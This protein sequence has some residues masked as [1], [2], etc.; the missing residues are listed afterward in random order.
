[1]LLLGQQVLTEEFHHNHSSVYETI[2][3]NLFERPVESFAEKST[4]SVNWNGIRKGKRKDNVKSKGMGNGNVS[5][6]GMMTQGNVKAKKAMRQGKDMGNANGSRNGKGK[7]KGR[8][9][10]PTDKPTEPPTNKPTQSPTETPP[11]QAA[12]RPELQILPR[13]LDNGEVNIPY[14]FKFVA[15]NIPSEVKSLRFEWLPGLGASGSA[16]KEVISGEAATEIQLVYSA[17]GSYNLTAS[18]SSDTEVLA[19]AIA[20]ITIGEELP[21]VVAFGGISNAYSAYKG[22]VDLEWSP[23]IC[24]QNIDGGEFL[25]SAPPGSC[26]QM[27]Y[28]I[29]YASSPYEFDCSD[30]Q[31]IL[32]R[33]SNGQS[34]LHH[35]S[36]LDETSYSLMGLQ[37]D[38][39]IVLL[40]LAVAKHEKV[41]SLVCH[42]ATVRV[43]SQDPVLSPDITVIALSAEPNRVSNISISEP[44]N[45]LDI[46]F[47]AKLELREND[48][49]SGIDMNTGQPFLVQIVIIE[50]DTESLF[51]GLVRE[52][53][54]TEIFDNLTLSADIPSFVTGEVSPYDNYGSRRYLAKKN[55]NQK[56]DLSKGRIAK[57]KP[58]SCESGKSLEIYL[59][60]EFTPSAEFRMD[61][62]LC[63]LLEWCSGLKRL[64]TSLELTAAFDFSSVIKYQQTGE[65]KVEK[66]ST[67]IWSKTYT[68]ILWVGKIPVL[69]EAPMKLNIAAKANIAANVTLDLETNIEIVKKYVAGYDSANSAN[70]VFYSRDISPQPKFKNDVTAVLQ[71]DFNAHAGL[72]FDI[73]L[74]LYKL[75]GFQLEI[76][77]GA[78]FQGAGSWSPLEK[79]DRFYLSDF[80]LF[81]FLNVAL[82]SLIRSFE[83]PSKCTNDCLSKSFCEKKKDAESCSSCIM[84]CN[85][86]YKTSSLWVPQIPT[87]HIFQLPKVKINA[88]SLGECAGDSMEFLLEPQIENQQHTFFKQDNPKTDLTPMRWTAGWD[89]SELG[90]NIS[91][92]S[93]SALRLRVP[94]VLM[95]PL[96]DYQVYLESTPSIP[97][98][99][100]S[101]LSSRSLKLAIPFTVYDRTA[102]RCFDEYTCKSNDGI[103][104]G[105]CQPSCGAPRGI[106]LD[107]TDCHEGLTCCMNEAP[108]CTSSDGR[109]G[110][111]LSE[112]DCEKES[113]PS[114]M[115]PS[116]S[117]SCEQCCVKA[118]CG[119][120][121]VE[122]GEEC[123]PGIAPENIFLR[124]DQGQNQTICLPPGDPNACTYDHRI[125]C[126]PCIDG[127][128]C[129]SMAG[130]CREG[131][132]L[133]PCIAIIDEDSSI[134]TR[135]FTRWSNFRRE[136]P[137][138]LFCLVVPTE[139][140]CGTL[141]PPSNFM[142]EVAEGSGRTTLVKHIARD[143][144]N[145]SLAT[146]LYEACRLNLAG[147]PDNVPF[148]GVFVDNSGSMYAEDVRATVDLL[149]E[150][151]SDLGMTKRTI[152]NSNENWID[153][154]R[155]D[156]V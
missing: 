40:V 44:A 49:V 34:P 58:Y 55:G 10:P 124:E 45:R 149:D 27:E 133:V 148:V 47:R 39:D 74:M 120:G 12:E 125:P 3:L 28:H 135:A 48:Y 68:K 32:E 117:S 94:L 97:G 7:G 102:R 11:E 136:Y 100:Y 118:V 147:G 85:E 130:V 66:P 2:G 131:N 84:A 139:G 51:S 113:F 88:K 71:A 101:M 151:L 81:I 98:L 134:R 105:S 143:N 115:F 18:I 104:V 67:Q 50:N 69:I 61:I 150:M 92:T 73:R 140:C 4:R 76:N 128:F 99:S 6:N 16:N 95:Q 25:V 112:G 155:T 89:S 153:P 103:Y 42:P 14:T 121:I 43:G 80:R 83:N 52:A 70:S 20:P 63:R 62:E 5:A 65:C 64:S 107:S 145:P 132:Q 154:F 93:S 37:E 110:F 129:D 111:C 122:K 82:N 22:R 116:K 127:D 29:F 38:Q 142:S 141:N 72:V 17:P 15:Q 9:E 86:E 123:D 56:V 53:Y 109:P 21:L 26:V 114:G 19:T 78:Q 35:L 137:H 30:V 59:S 91:S 106:P 75:I 96:P 79:F 24:L 119:N 146:N 23:A 46:E 33:Y 87:Y 152:V 41:A 13:R 57:Q 138:R 144:G 156:L 77:P 108:R 31:G 60:G 1:M 8:T 54:V 126:D 36:V 90:W